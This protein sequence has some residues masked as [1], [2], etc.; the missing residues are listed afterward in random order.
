MNT[1]IFYVA[2]LSI[3]I[4]GLMWQLGGFGGLFTAEDPGEGLGTTGNVT[5]QANDSAI[6]DDFS[7][8][9]SSSSDD[10]GLVGLIVSGGQNI[11]GMLTIVVY[12][13]YDLIS[14]GLPP[15]AAEP[16]G[17][18]AAILVSIGGIQLIIGRYL[19]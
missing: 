5:E 14:L 9:A 8:E 16:I 15:Y 11:M 2:V 13:P 19:R 18:L 4:G 1:K 3:A 10:G 6:K 17:N 12:L 7:G